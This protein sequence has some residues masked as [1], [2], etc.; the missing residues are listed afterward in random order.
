MKVI[1]LVFLS[2]L[3]SCEEPPKSQDSILNYKGGEVIRNSLV[4]VGYYKVR[5]RMYDTRTKRYVVKVIYVS[6]AG[7]YFPGQTIK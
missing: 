6:D 4:G 3:V 5:I 2:L 7:N 1:L